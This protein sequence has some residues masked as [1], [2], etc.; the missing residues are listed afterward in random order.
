M[1]YTDREVCYCSASSPPEG[2]DVRLD[3]QRSAA[4]GEGGDVVLTLDPQQLRVDAILGAV[5]RVPNVETLGLDAAG[6]AP[7][8]GVLL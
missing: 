2:V 7:T 8:T 6:S 4:R 3:T 5:R 1:S